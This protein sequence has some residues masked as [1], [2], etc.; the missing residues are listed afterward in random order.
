MAVQGHVSGSDRFCWRPY[1][2]DGGNQWT[3]GVGRTVIGTHEWLLHPQLGRQAAWLQG[4]QGGALLAILA[5]WTPMDTCINRRQHQDAQ[6][7]HVLPEIP[8]AG[9]WQGPQEPAA[10]PVPQ[11]HGAANGPHDGVGALIPRSAQAI[12]LVCTAGP[13]RQHRPEAGFAGQFVATA[14]RSARNIST[15]RFCARPSAVALLAIGSCS[16]RPWIVMRLGFTPRAVR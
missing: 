2:C 11:T 6:A 7:G 8:T 3:E 13:L 15:R 5:N 16:P 4:G 12:H 1:P 9:Q 10:R 14:D